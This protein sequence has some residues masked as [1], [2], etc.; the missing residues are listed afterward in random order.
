[1]YSSKDLCILSST[2]NISPTGTAATV[3]H[4]VQY[5]SPWMIEKTVTWGDKISCLSHIVFEICRMSDRW[6]T[7]WPKQKVLTL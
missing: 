7:L 3:N 5:Q 1:V 2:E 6:Q 4:K